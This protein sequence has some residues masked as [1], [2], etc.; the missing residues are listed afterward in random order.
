MH[1]GHVIMFFSGE[2]TIIKTGIIGTCEV[3]D[4]PKLRIAMTNTH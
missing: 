2:T 1:T 3:T 4:G